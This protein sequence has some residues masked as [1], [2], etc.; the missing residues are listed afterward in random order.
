MMYGP[1]GEAAYSFEMTD[2]LTMDTKAI[3]M[4]EKRNRNLN[5]KSLKA[6]ER[7]END[8]QRYVPLLLNVFK[9]SLSNSQFITIRNDEGERGL[10]A[11]NKSKLDLAEEDHRIFN[12]QSDCNTNR[13][14]F[15]QIKAQFE[16]A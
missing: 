4:A 15:K 14:V 12:A 5:A 8:Q 1:Y 13:D 16:M 7:K 10:S 9:M 11:N 6:S 2:C 3:D